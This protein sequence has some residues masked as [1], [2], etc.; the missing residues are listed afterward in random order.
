MARLLLPLEEI[1]LTSMKYFNVMF[2]TAS[3]YLLCMYK[4]G[5]SYLETGLQNLAQALLMTD[6]VSSVS[7]GEYNSSSALEIIILS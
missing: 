6:V 3:L 2:D 1:T 5:S 4:T 7:Q